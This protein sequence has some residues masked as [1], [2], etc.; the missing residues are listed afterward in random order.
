MALHLLMASER[1]LPECVGRASSMSNTVKYCPLLQCSMNCPAAAV[2]SIHAQTPAI[3][4]AV[5]LLYSYGV[6]RKLA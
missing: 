4:F 1:G 2:A 6:A 5:D 3:R